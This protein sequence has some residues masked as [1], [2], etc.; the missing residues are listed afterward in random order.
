MT[1]QELE[2]RAAELGIKLQ[3]NMRDETIAKKIKEA[4]EASS[5]GTGQTG[6]TGAATSSQPEQKKSASKPAAASDEVFARALTHIT[7]DGEEFGPDEE[8]VCTQQQREALIAAGAAIA[9]D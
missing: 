4:E 2:A 3:G 6:G 8:L 7:H 1:R 9:I 5:Q